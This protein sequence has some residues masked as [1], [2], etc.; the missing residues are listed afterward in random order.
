M[1]YT[2]PH[3]QIQDN[4]WQTR[5][6]Y[7]DEDIVALA[8]DIRRN[9]LLHSPIGRIHAINGRMINYEF[10]LSDLY[11][12]KVDIESVDDLVSYIEANSLSYSV[13]IA[14]GHTRLRAWRLLHAKHDYP[15]VMPID[16]R[17]LTDE[18]MQSIAWSENAQRKDITAWEEA[19]AIRKRIRDFEWTH[20][21]T[22][23]HLGLARATVSNKL[24]LLDLPEHVRDA[25]VGGRISERQA[26]ALLPAFLADP[27]IIAISKLKKWMSSPDEL[28]EAALGGQPAEAIRSD[29][30]RTTNWIEH[31]KQRMKEME[32]AG[33]EDGDEEAAA[34]E[35][36]YEDGV[37]LRKLEVQGAVERWMSGTKDKGAGQVMALLVN[38]IA[39]AGAA[40][41]KQLSEYLADTPTVARWAND[42][43]VDLK[44]IFDGTATLDEIDGYNRAYL[45]YILA[46]FVMYGDLNMYCEYGIRPRDITCQTLGI[47]EDD[48]VLP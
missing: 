33:D 15:P 47:F 46:G 45:P 25:L 10:P 41:E 30:K 34:E 28:F 18:D 35:I 48:E 39:P 5:S 32:E 2:I 1:S 4:P 31:E 26:M 8:A 21:E 16:L 9:G 38:R 42:N 7:S 22:A 44:T 17:S 14:C 27:E 23:S 11:G 36:E 20:E 40:S 12:D 24:R 37:E 19:L 43:I 6:E 29:W 3:K 13:Q